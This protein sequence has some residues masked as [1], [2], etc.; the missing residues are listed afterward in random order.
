[1]K[2]G[3]QYLCALIFLALA[4]SVAPGLRA[5]VTLRYETE[6]KPAAALQPI[7]EQFMKAMQTGTSTSIRMKGNQG[8]TTAGKWIEIFDFT[9]G[10]VTLVDPASK[11]FAALPLSQLVDKMAGAMPQ[12]APQQMQAVQQILASM[13]TSVDSKVTGKTT[14][15]QGVQAEE[16]EITF[17][18]EMPMPAG[19]PKPTGPS[20]NVKMVMHIWTAK[21]EEALRL[22]AIR[23]L[24]GYQAWQ[25]YIMNPAGMF[26]K[27]AGKMPG[28]ANAIGPLVDEMSKNQSVILRNRMEIYMPFLAVVA[29]QMATQGQSFPALDPDAPLI[30]I[31]QEVAEL[32]TAPVDASLFEIPKDYTAVAADDMFR[33]MFKAQ[34]AAAAK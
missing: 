28:M 26:E 12:A 13:K 29:K 23:E 25:K 21:K 30:E 32:S 19:M 1:M 9:K 24:T 27:L 34:S 2:F 11:T 22:P 5:D 15:I 16:R 18:M 3:K 8:Y 4:V 10:D 33:D 20:I 6:F 17:T 7:M 31:D 14:E